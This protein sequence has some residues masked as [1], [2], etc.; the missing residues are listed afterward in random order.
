MPNFT[1]L[2]R[3]LRDLVYEH[4]FATFIKERRLM[5]TA[6]LLFVDK[7]IGARLIP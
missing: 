6:A 2:P 5:K 1:D 3:E 4:Y 7:R